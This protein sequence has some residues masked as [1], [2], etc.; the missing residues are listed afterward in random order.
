MLLPS[1]AFSE[2]ALQEN[3]YV[4][5][6]VSTDGDHEFLIKIQYFFQLR[7]QK[8]SPQIGFDSNQILNLLLFFNDYK[9]AQEMG[10]YIFE[11][12]NF[13]GFSYRVTQP[14]FELFI[15]RLVD[16][17]R[18][19]RMHLHVFLDRCFGILY[20]EK[21]KLLI[22]NFILKKFFV[23]KFFAEKV[24]S[25]LNKIG[26]KE[27]FNA[28][29]LI[30]EIADFDK[31][32]QAWEIVKYTFCKNVFNLNFFIKFSD[33]SEPFICYQDF[34][35]KKFKQQITITPKMGVKQKI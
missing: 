19:R 22:K 1:N 29:D 30:Y 33:P 7:N 17:K 23:D 11:K 15:P 9:E 31:F 13:S 34:L 20:F 4:L 25:R 2:L 35:A 12:Y 26:L 28:Q 16:E 24:M 10:E 27:V 18:Y 14:S 21:I 32:Y 8:N 5:Q 3:K 6:A